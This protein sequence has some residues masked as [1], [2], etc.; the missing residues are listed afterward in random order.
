MTSS[1]RH[2]ANS[3]GIFAG[4]CSSIVDQV[5][6]RAVEV[7]WLGSINRTVGWPYEQVTGNKIHM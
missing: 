4:H 3:A 6:K 2:G 1:I 7:L 5:V